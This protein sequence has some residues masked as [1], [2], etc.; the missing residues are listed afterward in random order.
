MIRGASNMPKWS[1]TKNRVTMTQTKPM[2]ISQMCY[3]LTRNNLTLIQWILARMTAI[4]KEREEY[5]SLALLK[6]IWHKLKLMVQRQTWILS[7]NKNYQTTRQKIQTL[8]YKRAK[9]ISNLVWMKTY[10]CSQ[11]FNLLKISISFSNSISHPRA[12][13]NRSKEQLVFTRMVN[14]K[15]SKNLWCLML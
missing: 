10:T 5:Q 12:Q 4:K 6:I 8:V 3:F 13:V 2:S 11:S 9:Q 7:L 15:Q 14:S 1:L